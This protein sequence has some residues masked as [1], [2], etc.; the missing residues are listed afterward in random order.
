MSKQN[1]IAA[2]TRMLN[3]INLIKY[4]NIDE[5]YNDCTIEL[6]KLTK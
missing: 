3:I 2:L 4:G 1:K 6:E 5:I